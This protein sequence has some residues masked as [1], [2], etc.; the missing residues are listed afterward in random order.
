MLK[1][2]LKKLSIIT[3]ELL[4]ISGA[5]WYIANKKGIES[6]G[7]IG[8]RIERLAKE[9][10]N[11]SAQELEQIFPNPSEPVTQSYS[12]EYAG[13]KYSLDETLHKSVYQYYRGEPKT[14]SYN[15]DDLPTNWEE[16]YYGMFLKIN[17]A[18]K[19]IETLADDLKNLGKKHNLN[20]DQI[21]DLTLA[22]VQ[23]IEY[24]DSK[25]ENILAQSE[26]VFML[27]PYELLFE[28]KGVCSDKSLLAVALLRQM[29]YGA[30]LFAYEQDNHMAIGIQCPKEYSTYGSGYCYAETTAI[31]NKI[32]IIPE[33][34]HVTNKT[35]T[36]KEM[37]SSD[38][39]ASQQDNLKQ[40]GQVTTYQKTS[41]KEYFGIIAT[42]KIA[43][44]IENLKKSIDEMKI[45]LALQRKEIQNQESQLKNMKNDLDDLGKSQNIEKYNSLVKKYNNYLEKY[46][47]D[48]KKFNDSVTLYNKTI[49]RYNALIKQ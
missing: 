12:W 3:L 30:A 21:V 44:E 43:K 18:D 32:G 36:S 13:A 14:F 45:K 24:D 8:S 26:N 2:F 47:K 10:K 27:R 29:G 28:K 6:V 23:S 20:D 40:L 1:N 16:Q 11:G 22:F 9:V 25:A 19:T 41:G 39:G 4:L 31:G 46:K 37:I 42:Q 17:E 33:L 35:V 38:F 49:S 15:D 48:I 34:D 7:E 5:L